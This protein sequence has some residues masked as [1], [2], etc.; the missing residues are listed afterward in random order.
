L[1]K[2]KRRIYFT[3]VI[4]ICFLAG[5]Y[6]SFAHQHFANTGKTNHAF[7]TKQK[8]QQSVREKCYLCDMMHHT[9]M[10]IFS[11]ATPYVQFVI[12]NTLYTKQ[13]SYTGIALILSAGRSPPRA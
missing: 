4:F 3:W 8:P 5:Q 13:H 12:C 7:S 9:P 6:V 2:H 1:N 11:D 10:V